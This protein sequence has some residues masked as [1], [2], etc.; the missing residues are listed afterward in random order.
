MTMHR[1]QTLEMI[2]SW[3]DRPHLQMIVSHDPGLVKYYNF[4]ILYY[5]P[6]C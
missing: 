6:N 2:T 5:L 1:D 4:T 3:N